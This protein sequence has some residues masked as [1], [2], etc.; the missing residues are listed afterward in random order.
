MLWRTI[1]EKNKRHN[2][3]NLNSIYLFWFTIFNYKAGGIMKTILNGIIKENPLFVLVLGLC[4]SLAV[5][6]TFEKS[7]MMG[8][9]VLFVL[10]FS[11][12]IVS[13]IKK[14]VSDNIK[15]PVYILIIGTF[16]TILSLI[17][18]K[19][20]PNLYASFGIYLSLITVNCLVL[21]RAISFA[22]KNK[23]SK[24]ILDA[25]GIG[26]GYT[27]SLMIIGL[28]REVLGSNTL[29]IMNEIST[30]TGYRLILKNILPFPIAIFKTSAGAFVTIGLLIALFN[31][32]RS[33]Y[34]S[35]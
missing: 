11:N 13:L 28:I 24:S 4:S 1:I 8:L 7:Y 20:I 18:E 19:Y 22:S 27:I 9:S 26:L 34:E 2:S 33:K 10:V 31:F 32:I 29:T 3:F 25:I 23:V 15:I 6:T 17:I 30:L 16:V 5:T 14:L 35:N 21:G 12:M